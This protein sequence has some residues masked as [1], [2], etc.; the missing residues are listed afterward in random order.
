MKKVIELFAGAGGLALGLEKAGFKTIGLVEIDN[1]AS[2]TLRKNR[3]QWN[4]LNEDITKIS[5]QNLEK[6][7]N[8]KR[9]ELDLL[10]GGYP[11]QSFSFAGNRK[12]IN[13]TRGTMFYHYAIFLKKLKPK[14][15][16][17]ENVKGLVSHDKGKTLETMLKIFSEIGYDVSWRI[18]NAWDY[19]VAQ[20]R[21]RIVIIGIR[22]DL[23]KNCVYEFPI[24]NIY[25][26]VL[27]DV[28]HGVP[29][30]EGIK[31]SKA[32][33]DIMKLIPQG[34]Y[35]KSLPDEIARDYM[36]SCYFM[37]G[38][39]TG[40]ARRISWFEPCL[41]LTCSPSQKQTERCHPEETRPFTIR[42][43]ARIQ[44][45]PDDWKFVGSISN[46]YKQ[47]GNAVP[48]ELAKKIG[49]SIIRTLN[50]MEGEKKMWNLEFIER[51]SL[52]KHIEETIKIYEKTL[53][54]YNLNK[55][56]KNVID[57]IKLTFDSKV[58]RRE[59]EEVINNEI[60][61]QRD[62][63]NTNA[64]GYFHQN[65]FKY[66]KNCS[67][68]KR[69][70]DIIFENGKKSTYI[71]MKNKH[72][73]M[74]SSSSQKIFMN[75]QNKIMKEPESECY[76]V[77]IMAKKSQNKKWEVSIDSNK[78]SDDRIRRVS[79]DKFY[80]IV[81]GDV[82]AFSKICKQI[83]ILIDEILKENKKYTVKEDTVIN[84]LKHIDSNIEKAIYMLAF[85]T[86][87]GF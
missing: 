71:E 11:C 70:F 42:E 69:G 10:S 52:K 14:M 18:L 55:F 56:N 26:P 27:N 3:P 77:E 67:V 85:K 5:S 30:S 34:E 87:E 38:G 24:K 83:P 43:Y 17:A 22:N 40:I 82:V 33:Y 58:Y 12:G 75:M 4:V 72:N 13:D 44:S 9:E 73:T 21:Q 84:E 65:I 48:V 50:E 2:E 66:M 54:V 51:D 79:I 35:W 39:R 28:L 57:P 60:F 16:L 32:K 74:N 29:K 6:I 20:K 46:Q 76:L 31:Y 61:R 7:F 78:V 53:N 41:T 80:E 37:G 64:I 49:F 23:V 1:S 19:G 62:K 68:P 15:F 36:K 47:I 86:Y 63:T 59:L 8:I 81:T 25:K 45:F